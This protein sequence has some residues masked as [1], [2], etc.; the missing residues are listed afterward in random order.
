M[1]F[2]RLFCAGLFILLTV[3]LTA[4]QDTDYFAQG[5][6][7]YI[8]G[9]E[10][11]SV[12]ALEK[13]IQRNPNHSQARE[14]FRLILIESAQK[15]SEENN[16]QSALTKVKKLL[17]Y[18]PSDSEA[19]ALAA[20]L[21]YVPPKV[22]SKS[23]RVPT[24]EKKKPVSKQSASA[25]A[26]VK[27]VPKPV[28]SAIVP[29]AA[30]PA[31]DAVTRLEARLKEIQDHW[32][33]ERKLIQSQSEKQMLMR[34][35]LERERM[36]QNTIAWS[37]MSASGFGLLC[38]FV[39]MGMSTKMVRQEK[40][41][42]LDMSRALLQMRPL[43]AREGGVNMGGF[44][45][46]DS[47][48]EGFYNYLQHHCQKIFTALELG[49][50]SFA[51][52]T[53]SMVERLIN[54]IH[55]NRK[56]YLRLALAPV[57][58]ANYYLAHPVNVAI[59]ATLTGL[60]GGLEDEECQ[61]LTLAALLHDVGVAKMIPILSRSRMSGKNLTR[62]QVEQV[63][64]LKSSEEEV[65]SAMVDFD[66]RTCQRVAAIISKASLPPELL[67]I[68][69][70]HPNKVEMI[71]TVINVCES[72]ET[73]THY[74]PYHQPVSPMEAAA[75]MQN[76]LKDDYARRVLRWMLEELQVFPIGTAVRLSSGKVGE[77]TGYEPRTGRIE[78]IAKKAAIGRF[79][80]GEQIVI[81]HNSPL[82]IAE[83]LS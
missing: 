34:L 54:E 78:I 48:P 58:S 21:G 11:Q 38:L 67:H 66:E 71:A 29:A 13:A 81:S 75:K 83:I 33:Q 44:M 1:S 63:N 19:L 72:F 45:H 57:T 82:R 12:R 18:I 42:K 41:I 8:Q 35:E 46:D 56:E 73:S 43:P 60:R 27:V 24:T 32:D 77:V 4:A 69:T 80:L 50:S 61:E 5:A 47:T 55:R 52:E 3:Q 36:R 23:A 70:D 17:Q 65:I 68:E 20:D 59:L 51:L 2:I 74:R 22:Q 37:I 30:A 10:D 25:P 62:D 79:T 7:Y 39:Y 53:K 9:N 15:E 40:K 64:D 6:D 76:N 26:S 16:T 14:L 49:E 31:E 28:P